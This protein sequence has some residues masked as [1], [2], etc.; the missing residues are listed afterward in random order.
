MSNIPPTR[1]A[2]TPMYIHFLS[3]LSSQQGN[4]QNKYA[5]NK[6]MKGFLYLDTAGKPEFGSPLKFDMKK[7]LDSMYSASQIN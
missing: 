1:A 2:V 5:N 4:S 7:N 6:G 3:S